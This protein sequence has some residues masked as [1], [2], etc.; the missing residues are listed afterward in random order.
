LEFALRAEGY[1]VVPTGDIDAAGVAQRHYDCTVIDHH[2]LSTNI[3]AGAATC[4][5]LAPVILLANQAPH[6][7]SPWAFRTL[8]KPLLG[9]ALSDAVR[10]AVSAVGATT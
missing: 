1:E 2:A 4:Q 5:A 6:P 9:V 8:L 3:E 7:L 10:D